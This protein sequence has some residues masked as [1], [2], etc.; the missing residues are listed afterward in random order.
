MGPS[1]NQLTVTEAGPFR[2]M[3]LDNTGVAFDNLEQRLP[4]LTPWRVYGV[5]Y[6]D[7]ELSNRVATPDALV[8]RGLRA[9]RRQAEETRTG[10]VCS[11]DLFGDLGQ[12]RI[13]R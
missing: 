10:P 8:V 13:A 5:R 9:G 2:V 6:G 12:G 11:R 7:P 4:A 1:M 3:A